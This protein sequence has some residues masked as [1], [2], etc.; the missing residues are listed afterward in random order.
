MGLSLNDKINQL[1]KERQNKIE[2]HAQQLI[3][4]ELTLRDLRL[5]LDKT[6]IELCKVLDMK[7]DGISRLEHRSDM[8]MSTLGKYI[9]AMGGN[10]KIIA[11]FPDRAPVQIKGLENFTSQRSV[12]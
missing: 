4:E 9:N 2:N 11:E 10:L 7:Q 1:P 8:L 6:Q 3:E 12:N 5:A